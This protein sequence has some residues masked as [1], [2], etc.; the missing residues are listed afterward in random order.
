MKKIVYIIILACINCSSF[1]QILEEHVPENL[2]VFKSEAIKYDVD[3]DGYIDVKSI[4]RPDC[5]VFYK[6]ANYYYNSAEKIF[7]IPEGTKENSG[8]ERIKKAF[9]RSYKNYVFK[10]ESELINTDFQKL[11]VLHAPIHD[12]KDWSKFNLP[13]LREEKGFSFRGQRYTDENDGIFYMSPNIIAKTGNSI[14][15]VWNLYNSY[16]TL[17]KYVIINDNRYVKYGMLN[18]HEI[19]LE[20]IK[21]LNYKS[22]IS[23]YFQFDISKSLEGVSTSEYDVIVEQICET[24]DIDLPDFKIQCMVHSGP[25]EARLF[26]NWFFLLGCNVLED[27]VSFG[28]AHNGVIHVIG[29]GKGLISHESFH[30]VWDKLVGI[31]NIFFTEGTQMYYEFIQDS[32]KITSALEVM[33][34]YKDY[35]LK[36]LIMGSNFF[37]APHENNKIISYPMSGLFSMYLIEKYGLEK[38]KLLFKAEKGEN[39]FTEVYGLKLDTILADFYS[40]VDSK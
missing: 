21:Q 16:C 33:K 9:S 40:W 2:D 4:P 25:N 13:I 24:M 39:G 17:Y 31:R 37:N 28:A 8:L 12:Y 32:S 6:I 35:D 11:L 10:K 27:S 29:E 3:A 38:Y 19:D 7:V 20:K 14:T 5:E 26:S 22:V 18:G 1:G 15:P 36:S 23:K 30:A 34:K